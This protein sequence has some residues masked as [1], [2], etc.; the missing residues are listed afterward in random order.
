MARDPGDVFGL[1][2]K[3]CLITGG[4][5][6]IGLAS[7]RLLQSYGA[8]LALVDRDA[9]ALAAVDLGPEVLTIAADVASEPDT[10]RYV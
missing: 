5:G 1:Q 4:A 9:D 2:G 7:A 10:A 8:K 3:V 6:S